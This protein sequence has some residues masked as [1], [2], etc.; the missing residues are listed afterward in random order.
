[1]HPPLLLLLLLACCTVA[2]V[3]GVSAIWGDV[4]GIGKGGGRPFGCS[5][6]SGSHHLVDTLFDILKPFYQIQAMAEREHVS[7]QSD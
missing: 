6:R 5:P 1:M 4:A 3:G 2:W 7:L